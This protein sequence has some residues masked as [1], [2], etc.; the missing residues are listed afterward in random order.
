[1]RISTEKQYNIQVYTESVQCI[2]IAY[3]EVHIGLTKISKHS[4]L[5]WSG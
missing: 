1:M 2:S 3:S 5:E 4:R